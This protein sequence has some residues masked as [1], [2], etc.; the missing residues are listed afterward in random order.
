MNLLPDLTPKEAVQF[1]K[2]L[3]E[4]IRSRPLPPPRENLLIAGADCSYEK[5]ATTGYAAIVVCRWPSM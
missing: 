3:V 4:M 1:Q 2:Q 5:R